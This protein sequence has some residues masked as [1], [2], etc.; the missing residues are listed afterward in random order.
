MM[1]DAWFDEY[2][3]AIVV[4]RRFLDADQAAL[5]AQEPARLP[6]WHPLA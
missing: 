6:P 2:V 5:L 1:T 4:H 3:Y